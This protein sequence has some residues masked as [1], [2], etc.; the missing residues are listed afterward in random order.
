ME[1]LDK[2]VTTKQPKPQV[3]L[4]DYKF[5]CF[6]GE[7]KF[8]Y[9]IPNRSLG[10][11]ATLGV[12]DMQFNKL[13]VY[14]CDEHRSEEKVAKPDNFEVMVDVARKLSADFPHV[15]VDLYNIEGTIVFGELT[16]YDGSGY[17]HYDPDEFDFKA[18]GYFVEY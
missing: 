16:F 8:M 2:S 18:G 5:F 7:P 6:N 17:Y 1:N 3:G 9:V 11:Y 14:R 15:R 4:T 12:Y 10:E 13:P